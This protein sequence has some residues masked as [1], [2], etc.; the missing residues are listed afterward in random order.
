MKGRTSRHKYNLR[1]KKLEK[2]NHLALKELT[3]E[4][5]IYVRTPHYGLELAANNIHQAETCLLGNIKR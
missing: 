5:G 1:C 2:S 3:N 4:K